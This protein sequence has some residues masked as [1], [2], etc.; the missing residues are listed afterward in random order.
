MTDI[1]ERRRHVREPAVAN[2]A[3]L[4]WWSGQDDQR[5]K[6]TLSDIS[7]GGARIESEANPSLGQRVWFRLDEPA[8]TTWVRA[9]VIRSDGRHFTALEFEEACPDELL[10]TAT[11]GIVLDFRNSRTSLLLDK[12]PGGLRC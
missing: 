10:L 6:A 5:T 8:K 1:A 7:R 11:L 2:R 12:Q 3:T 4:E 9:K